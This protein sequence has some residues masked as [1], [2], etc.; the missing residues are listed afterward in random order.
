MNKEIFNDFK[1]NSYKKIRNV[2]IVDNRYVLKSNTNYDHR[3]YN[4][5]TNKDFKYI[6]ECSKYKE[7]D[8]F[9]YIDDEDI[10]KEE[11]GFKLVNILAFLHNKTTYYRETNLDNIKKIYEDL[12]EKINDFKKYYYEMQDIIEQKMYYSPAEH[13]LINNISLIYSALDFSKNCLDKWYSKKEEQKKERVVL[14]HN[15]PIL[16]HL[17]GNKLI[18]W[19]SYKRDIPIYDF[20]YF[21]RHNYL[22]LEMLSLYEI[23]QSKYKYSEEEKMLFLSSISIPDK[24]VFTNN[25]Y[26]N[27]EIVNNV[28]TYVIKTRDFILN[29]NN[30]TN[31]T[32]KDKF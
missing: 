8:L 11:R 5:L 31:E 14:L 6:V 18:S 4:Y 12:N 32:N 16:E 13:L 27:T 24:I 20:I 1:T 29:E 26:K 25:N 10:P 30:K 2:I 7:Y 15:K 19:N 23:Y 22:D 21:Y 3:I 17:V 9:P 28:I